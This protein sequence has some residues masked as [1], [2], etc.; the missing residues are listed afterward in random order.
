[1]SK[2][3]VKQNN[4]YSFLLMHEISDMH[5][6]INKMQKRMDDDCEDEEETKEMF[7]GTPKILET[8]E[9]SSY[10]NFGVV[11]PIEV[12]TKKR[13]TANEI[14]MLQTFL[15]SELNAGIGWY[16]VVF[17]GLKDGDFIEDD[18][19]EG[20]EYKEEDEE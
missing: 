8:E 13:L 15:Q 7:G 16:K 20:L 17:L 9:C 12:Q 19:I 2:K 10:Y 14:F 3:I 5:D 6:S 1:M 18:Y 4:I 11:K